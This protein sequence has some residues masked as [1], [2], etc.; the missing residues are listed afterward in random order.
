MEQMYLKIQLSGT[1]KKKGQETVAYIINTFAGLQFSR[2]K[3]SSAVAT[4][5]HLGKT[6]KQDKQQQHSNLI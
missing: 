3:L 1:T 4:V 6:N 2:I 5:V